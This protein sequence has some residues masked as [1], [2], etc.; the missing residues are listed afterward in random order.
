MTVRMDPERV[1]ELWRTLVAEAEEREDQSR[2]P[3]LITLFA[4]PHP[5]A[6]ESRDSDSGAGS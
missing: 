3:L 6:V 4:H 1:R 2:E 5:T